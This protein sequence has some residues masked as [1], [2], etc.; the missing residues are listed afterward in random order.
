MAKKIPDHRRG[1]LGCQ[2]SPWIAQNEDHMQEHDLHQLLLSCLLPAWPLWI[3]ALESEK[4]IK[5]NMT[6]NHHFMVSLP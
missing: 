6:R 5:Y 2:N 4:G 3:H 1:Q